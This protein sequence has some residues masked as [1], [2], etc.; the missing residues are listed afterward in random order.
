MVTTKSSRVCCGRAYKLAINASQTQ[1]AKGC[2]CS[3]GFRGCDRFYDHFVLYE[4]PKKDDFTYR[5][6]IVED[7]AKTTLVSTGKWFRNDI[8]KF[9]PSGTTHMSTVCLQVISKPRVCVEINTKYSREMYSQCV[10]FLVFLKL[11]L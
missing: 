6:N 1:T 9:L 11:L 3:V 5:G 8:A 7:G 2:L 10:S 4:P